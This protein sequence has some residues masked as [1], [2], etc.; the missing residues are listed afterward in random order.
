LTIVLIDLILTVGIMFSETHC[1]LRRYVDEAVNR[2]KKA[3]LE[4]ILAVG[5]DVPSSKKAIETARKYK[6]VKAC[7][8]LDPWFADEFNRDMIREF[9]NLARDREVVAMSEIG[10]D[11]VAR[12]N[13]EGE[14]VYEYIDKEIQ[15]EAFR[16]HLRLAEKL[17][18]PVIVHDR[19]PDQELLDM[20]IEEGNLKNGAA[21]HN[22][23]NSLWIGPEYVKKCISLG[24]YLSYGPKLEGNPDYVIALKNTPLK[25]ILT[26]T[27]S[28]DPENIPNVAE[29]IAKL[30]NKTIEEIGTMATDNLKKLIGL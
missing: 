29:N 28:N 21:I 6:E 19:T 7:I 20:L 12:R 3:G 2:A 11:Y 23:S 9:E 14:Y 30:K 25:W 22:P 1:H 26:E 8:G 17:S 15:R 16:E 5:T 4:L 13:R 18:L 24:I 27:D 10:L